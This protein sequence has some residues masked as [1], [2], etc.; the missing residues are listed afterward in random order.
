MYFYL[1]YISRKTVKGYYVVQGN[2]SIRD[3]NIVME[4]LCQ[5][6]IKYNK[7]YK[8]L[9]IRYHE[10]NPLNPRLNIIH[11]TIQ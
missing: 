9:S 2:I 6:E 8:Q 7:Q 11:K 10:Y 4:K 1:A 5:I 3:I